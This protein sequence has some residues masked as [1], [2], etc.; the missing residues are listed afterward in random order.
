MN[1]RK[2]EQLAHHLHH[3][4]QHHLSHHHQQLHQ[5]HQ[6]QLQSD[7]QEDDDSLLIKMKEEM[8]EEMEEEMDQL[9]VP[10]RITSKRESRDFLYSLEN[11][12]N[13]SVCSMLFSNHNRHQ[14]HN[15][16]DLVYKPIVGRRS[17][18]LLEGH[19][20]G[21]DAA[22][23]NDYQKVTL[24]IGGVRY[25]TYKKTLKVI[26]ES[27]LANLTETNSD[28]D[29]ILNEYFFDRDPNSFLAI[30]NY[31]RT[32]KLHAP[33]DVCG[34]L[35]YEEMNFW[36]IGEQSIQPCCWTKYSAMRDCDEIL[37]KVMDSI[38][39]DEQEGKACI[40]NI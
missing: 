30:L 38:D 7:N 36:G 34:N 16:S 39:D 18:S 14:P 28:F 29:P 11:R 35:F 26:Q 19:I 10:H 40:I 32:G 5:Q 4:N 2:N 31:Y 20:P 24:N 12:K 23:N 6:D 9:Y 22:N 1:F 25:E 33:V 37:K 17:N 21:L 8:K 3:H 27:R 15:L 13:A